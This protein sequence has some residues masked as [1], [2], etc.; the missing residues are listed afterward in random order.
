MAIM[1]FSIIKFVFCQI[2]TYGISQDLR[3]INAQISVSS[4]GD[5]PKSSLKRQGYNICEEIKLF[6]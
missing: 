1:S 4:V 5:P 3:I 6:G 2:Q